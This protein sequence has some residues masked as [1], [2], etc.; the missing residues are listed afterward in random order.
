M[1]GYFASLSKCIGHGVKFKMFNF[2]PHIFC[3]EKSQQITHFL[4]VEIN[5]SSPF[6]CFNSEI[7]N[8]HVYLLQ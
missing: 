4:D 8:N 5:L 3:M 6:S 2:F 7:E 1:E